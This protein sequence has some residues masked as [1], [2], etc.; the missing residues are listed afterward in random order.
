MP[1]NRSE[2]LTDREAQIM[3]VLWEQGPSTADVIR[4]ALAAELHDSTVRTLL[5]VLES[6]GYVRH[7]ARGKAYVY[8]AVVKRAKAERKA[9][10][11]MLQ[12]FFGGSVEALVLRLMEDE[13][14]TPERIEELKKRLPDDRS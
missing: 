11:S 7:V 3:A 5:R 12:R 6:K 10:R 1:R 14:L 8:R 2:A 13:Q 4:E 9:V